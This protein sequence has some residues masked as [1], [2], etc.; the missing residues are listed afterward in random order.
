M[1]NAD[2]IISAELD[3]LS[4]N[5]SPGMPHHHVARAISS[6]PTRVEIRTEERITATQTSKPNSHP[7]LLLNSSPSR[8][9]EK[10]WAKAALPAGTVAARTRAFEDIVAASEASSPLNSSHKSPPSAPLPRVHKERTTMHRKA[11][12]QSRSM[13]LTRN[14]SANHSKTKS[15]SVIEIRS[16]DPRAAARVAAI[17]KVHHDFVPQEAG[18]TVSRKGKQRAESPMLDGLLREAEASVISEV[19]EMSL[20]RMRRSHS[21]HVSTLQ[22][23]PSK[24]QSDQWTK[25]DWRRLEMVL[26]DAQ[27]T[28]YEDATEEPSA[29]QVVN[30]YI[31]AEGVNRNDLIG[32]WSK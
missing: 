7:L 22:H 5:N 4:A 25:S 17:L 32:H 20:S 19:D 21:P 28:A 24:A 12:S 6:S 26:R 11:H 15:E 10:E 27:R 3:N 23:L 13:D 31:E 1:T 29:A 18:N 30:E 16:S 14:T 8:T 2:E 9:L